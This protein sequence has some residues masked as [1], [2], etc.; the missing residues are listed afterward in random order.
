M[1]LRRPPHSLLLVL[2]SGLETFN[3][4]SDCYLVDTL[5]STLLHLL[6]CSR[7]IFE[8]ETRSLYAHAA[9]WSV[10]VPWLRLENDHILIEWSV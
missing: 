3:H 8:S 5:R 7:R 2:H 1:N 9:V 10:G 6:D 4:R